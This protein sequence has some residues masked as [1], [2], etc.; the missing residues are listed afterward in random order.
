[1]K[2]LITKLFVFVLAIITVFTFVSCQGKEIPVEQAYGELETAIN[3]VAN[4]VNQLSISLRG[5]ADISNDTSSETGSSET[6]SEEMDSIVESGRYTATADLKIVTDND[7]KITSGS[8]KVKLTDTNDESLIFETY[9]KDGYNYT[10]T[11][12]FMESYS[13]EEYENEAIEL[14]DDDRENLKKAI[15]DFKDAV[16]A[17]TATQ[18]GKETTLVWTITNENKKEYVKAFYTLTG[19]TIADEE[20][21][22]MVSEVNVEKGEITLVINEGY[23]TSMKVVLKGSG[24]G[25]NLNAELTADISYKNVTPA[26][27]ETRLAEIRTEATKDNQEQ[28][29]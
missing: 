26:F 5:T 2:R 13:Y 16:P 11:N 3:K 14:E 15:K 25:V 22:N 10:Y 18:K 9:V 4:E 19:K 7:R 24:E 6:G 20:I 29:S 17:P 23:L 12:L 21:E 27:D 8:V 28:N 1:M